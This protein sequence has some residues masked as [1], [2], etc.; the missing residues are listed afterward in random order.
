MP[1]HRSTGRTVAP[2]LLAAAIAALIAA[3]C[4]RPTA[5]DLRDSFA[6]QLAANKFVKDFQR[7]GEELQ[8]TGPDVDG[9]TIRWR[10][11]VDSA[12]VESNGDAGKPFKGIV[13]SSWYAADR[14][15]V[16]TGSESNLPLE[17]ISNGVAQD[18]WA[19]WN[20]A[21]RRWEWE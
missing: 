17:L 20:T 9:S 4:G 13:K 3:G 7:R 5:D 10:V 1:A 15:V 8:F 12:V 14:R 19:L 21:T 18:C 16:P 6:Q 11:H 2:P